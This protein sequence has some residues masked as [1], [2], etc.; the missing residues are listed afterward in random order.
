MIDAVCGL[1]AVLSSQF[2]T[3]DFAPESNLIGVIGPGDGFEGAI[4]GFLRVKFPANVPDAERYQFDWQAIAS[5][6]NPFQNFTF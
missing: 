5:Q 4:G 3:H 6:N 1:T 2:W